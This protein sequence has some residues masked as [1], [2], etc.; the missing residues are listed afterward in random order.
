MQE[1][2]QSCTNPKQREALLKKS[3]SWLQSERHRIAEK[4]VLNHL[5]E[6]MILKIPE[7]EAKTLLHAA[8]TQTLGWLMNI[9]NN[10]IASTINGNINNKIDNGSSGNSMQGCG[11]VTYCIQG[12]YD[13]EENVWSPYLGLSGKLDMVL[14]ATAVV[15]KAPATLGTSHASVVLPLELKTGRWHPVKVVAHRAQVQAIFIH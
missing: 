11:S 3:N 14:K 1:K 15:T 4:C 8:L 13:I 6:L 5:E 7:V 12:I 10:G 9:C 2:I